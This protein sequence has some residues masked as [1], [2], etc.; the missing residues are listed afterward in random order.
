MTEWNKS[1]KTCRYERNH[2]L[3]NFHEPFPFDHFIKV[4][5]Q[6]ESD[7]VMKRGILLQKSTRPRNGLIKGSNTVQIFNG[8]DYK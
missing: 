6:S 5:T 2:S 8:Y 1:S 3:S 4:D 7:L